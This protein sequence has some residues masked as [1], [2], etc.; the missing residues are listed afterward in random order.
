LT[1][2]ATVGDIAGRSHANAEMV[3]PANQVEAAGFVLGK[4][5]RVSIRAQRVVDN[6]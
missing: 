1:G 6:V 2:P 4:A 3:C 5:D